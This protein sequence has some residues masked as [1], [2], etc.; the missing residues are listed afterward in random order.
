MGKINPSK[1]E[2]HDKKRIEFLQNHL[3]K[4]HKAIKTGINLKGYSAWSLTDNFEWTFGYSQRYGLIYI[5]FQTL[6]RSW[7]DS[8]H[9]YKKVIKENSI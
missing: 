7:K 4:V 3:K 9:F 1:G 5:D 8:A 6:K 2:I